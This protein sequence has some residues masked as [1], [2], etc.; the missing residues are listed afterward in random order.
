MDAILQRENRKRNGKHPY[1]DAMAFV[2]KAKVCNEKKYESVGYGWDYRY[3]GEKI[4]GS[5]LLH[6]EE[7]IHLSFFRADDSDKAGN[8][9]SYSRRRNFRL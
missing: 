7:V 5:S 8:I 3:D 6:E 4:V 2:E 1:D 9:S